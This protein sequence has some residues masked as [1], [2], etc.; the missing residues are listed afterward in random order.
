MKK[1]SRNFL[2]KISILIICLAFS[3]TFLSLSK[4]VS[5]SGYERVQFQSAGATLYANLYYPSKTLDF[6]EKRPLV[7]Y[8]HG[9]GSQRDFD[10]RIP[11]E[12]TKR[13]FYLAALD[14]Q[15]HGESG[16]S[17]NNMVPGEGI[18]A[19]A[20]DC[21]RLLDKLETMP[22]YSNVNV[23]QIGLIGHSLGGMVVLMNQALDDRFNVTVAWAPLVDFN[24][25]LLGIVETDDFLDYIPVN[26]LNTT[27]THNL[28]IIMSTQDEVLNFTQN[29]IKAQD[30][31]NCT[32][33]PI[34]GFLFG[35]GHQLFSDMVI[36]K[37]INWFEQH[38][39][40]SESINGPIVT[41][42]I[43][44]YIF[45]FLTLGILIA[46]IFSLVSYSA[47]YFKLKES[48]DLDVEVKKK[49]NLRRIK[50]GMKI[51]K[52]IVY[53]G[54]FIT[55][56]VLF[57]RFFGLEGIFYASLII[58]IIYLTVILTIR[59][60]NLMKKEEKTN[61]KEFIISKLQIKHL[62]YS[63]FITIF[64]LIILIIFSISY[65]TPSLPSS[66]FLD[67]AYIIILIILLSSIALSFSFAFILFHLHKKDRIR[68]EFKLNLKNIKIKNK[69]FARVYIYSIVCTFYFLIIYFIFSYSYP[70]AFMWPSNY[71]NFVLTVVAF[72]ILFSME[73]LYRK[74]IYPN[75]SFLS[76]STR[77][78]II[79]I[80]AIVIQITL[81][82]LTSSWSFFPSVLFTYFMFLYVV[83]QNT[84]I[85][86]NTH[87]FAAL[88]LSSFIIIQIFF[89]AVISNALGIG[90]ALSSFVK[91]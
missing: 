43:I 66:P 79:I 81:M 23:S 50:E 80:I 26:L 5:Y 59:Y 37:T 45:L 20:Q 75:L 60:R 40:H 14:Y 63:L 44:N 65:P 57:E 56:W 9:I 58:T 11:I 61:F 30:L 31:T 68:L 77:R 24:P 67:G 72:P 89:S 70:F 36:I 47:R 76:E 73:L 22:F 39:F 91:L 10:L 19:I 28:L 2:K 84:L 15:G 42:F 88:I 27:N 18:P 3:L 13:G 62:F 33:I 16:G 85:F 1:K 74:L 71:I 25:S 32:V 87:N 7:I 21:S 86:E 55:N 54:A 51:G 4:A 82:S 83:I 53:V 35:G 8:C 29:A 41:T 17:I 6:Q 48:N 90:S 52:I 46:M 38:F 64:F 12:L 69:R 49:F 78:K 34:T